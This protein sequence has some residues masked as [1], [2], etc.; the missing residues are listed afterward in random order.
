MEKCC[1]NCKH[2]RTGIKKCNKHNFTIEWL[3]NSVCD[4]F[5]ESEETKRKRECNFRSVNGKPVSV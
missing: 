3:S 2:S 1:E 4:S 5:E